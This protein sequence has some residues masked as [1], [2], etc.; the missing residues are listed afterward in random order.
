MEGGLEEH[1]LIS[2]AAAL[3]VKPRVTE[4]IRQR[5]QKECGSSGKKREGSKV[6]S[7]RQKKEIQQ[8]E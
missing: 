2:Q 6:N 3:E 7:N 1:L 4:E 8:Q 5:R